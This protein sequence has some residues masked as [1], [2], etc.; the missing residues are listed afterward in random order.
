MSTEQQ[1]TETD[2]FS[3]TL[4]RT[5]DAPVARVWQAWTTPEQYA[6]W[7][8]CAPGSVELDVRPGG[9]WKATVV[10]PDGGEFPM[11]GTYAEVAENRRLTIA[12]DIP[13]KPEPEKMTVDLTPESDDRTR[14]VV[15]QTCATTEE[16]DMAE[17]GT[18]MLLDSLTAEVT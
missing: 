18:T 7:A 1:T 5:L 11:T 12:M 3:Y 8:Y 17:Q 4:T 16:R 13:G 15:H 10:T 9:A 2:G 6:Q 14:L